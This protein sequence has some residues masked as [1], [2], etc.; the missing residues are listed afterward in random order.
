MPN[1]WHIADLHLGHTRLITGFGDDQQGPRAKFFA[2]IEEHDQAIIDNWNSVVKP[3]DKVY[4]MGDIALSHR[5]LLRVRL[6][7]GSKR[8]ILGNHDQDKPKIYAELFA[9]VY[10][11]K[12]LDG[13]V[14]THI[15]VHASALTRRSMKVN[16]HGHM[17]DQEIWV[18][19]DDFSL[20]DD[21]PDPRYRCVSCEQVNFTPV[22]HDEILA[23]FNLM[24]EAA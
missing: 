15:P 20:H 7:N 19:Q 8:A 17:H 12:C 3:A 23:G 22:H 13:M 1:I 2:T 21:Y 16:L 11:A 18:H 24:K 9:K 5:S 14:L 10:G 4:V 6:L